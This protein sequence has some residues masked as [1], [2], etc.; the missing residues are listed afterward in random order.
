ME[1]VCAKCKETKEM[2]SF[3]KDSTRAD[4]YQGICKKCKQKEIKTTRLREKPIRQAVINRM[5]AHGCAH[6][7]ETDV[8]V[9]QLHHWPIPMANLPWKRQ[10]LTES[11]RGVGEFLR[12]LSHCVV[13]CANCH[14]RSHAGLIELS[15]DSKHEE[16][17]LLEWYNEAKIIRVAR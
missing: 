7:G 15:E 10:G 11:S 17:E 14:L 8:I 16:N 13:L 5:K 2:S 3:Y 1:K 6:C 9:L 4:G 12:N